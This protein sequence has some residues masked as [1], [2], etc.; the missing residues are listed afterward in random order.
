MQTTK[1][2]IT[3]IL[4]ILAYHS[5]PLQAQKEDADLFPQPATFTTLITTPRAIE[6][7]TG[8][9]DGNLYLGGSGTAPCPIWRVNLSSPS[10]T[11]VGNIPAALATTC[12]FRGIAFDA[13]GRLFVVDPTL[14]RIY[15]FTPNAGTPPDATL[16]ATGVPGTN[17]LAFDRDGNLWTGDGTTGLGRIWKIV[18][19]GANCGAPGPVNC[20]EVFRVQPMRNSTALGGKVPGDGVGRQIRNFPPGTISIA[21]GTFPVT[22]AGGQDLVANGLA[23]NSNGDLFIIDTARGALWKAEFDQ[24]GRLTS[25]TGCDQTFTANTLCL[26]NIVVAHPILEGGDGIV[27]DRAENIWVAANERNAIVLIGKQGGVFEVFRNPVNASGLRNAADPSVGNNHVLEFPTSP[28]LNGTVFCTANSDLDRRD[29]SP[30]AAGEING[31]TVLGK[32]SCM[33]QPALIPG[34]PLPVR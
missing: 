10:L 13:A 12:T 32:I 25:P 27:L 23:F 20:T 24:K 26:S 19:A 7:L 8:D 18:G 2:A 11:V 21:G 6:G 4:V 17:G 34:F 9:N 3:A 29:N 14:G 1:R 31:T 22:P 5:L 30:A 16:F 15:S 28:V 33:D